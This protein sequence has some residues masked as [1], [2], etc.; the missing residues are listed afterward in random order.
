MDAESLSL[1]L[2]GAANFDRDEADR[3]VRS[4]HFEVRV[5]GGHS[6]FSRQLRRITPGAAAL[7]RAALRPRR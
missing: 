2:D 3:A 1:I 4:A 6:D 7:A 5:A